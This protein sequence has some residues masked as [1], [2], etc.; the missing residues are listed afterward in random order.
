[1]KYDVE[2]DRIS[3]M[4]A[5]RGRRDRALNIILLNNLLRVGAEE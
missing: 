1:M 4:H 2:G 3:Y 5:T